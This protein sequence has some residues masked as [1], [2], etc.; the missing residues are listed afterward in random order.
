MKCLPGGPELLASLPDDADIVKDIEYWQKEKIWQ[1]QWLELN[2]K[3]RLQRAKREASWEARDLASYIEG[4]QILK[5]EVHGQSTSNS[6]Y[7]CD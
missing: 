4:E 6:R 1:A 3:T 5:T 7:W 2:E